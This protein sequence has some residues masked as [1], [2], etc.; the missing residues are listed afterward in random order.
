MSERR[1]DLGW[2]R[3]FEAV[4]RLGSLTAAAQ[5]LG[6]SQPAVSYVIR[7]VEAQLGTTLVVRG[8]RGSALSPAGAALHRTV[9]ASIAE[10]DASVRSVRRMHRGPVL[11]LFTDYGFASFWM[12][13]RVPAF[14]RVRPDVE[15]R[16]I[17]SASTDLRSDEVE[18]VAVLF[19]AR[20]DFPDDAVLLFEERVVPVCSPAFAARH[21]LR[22]RPALIGQ[23]PL[24]HL[25][26]TPRPRWFTWA[27]WLGANGLAREAS[28]SDLSLNTYGLVVQA[29]LADQGL[30]LGWS[31]LIDDALAGGALVAVGAPLMRSG[32][33]YWLRRGADPSDAAADFVD[34]LQGAVAGRGS[35]Q[36]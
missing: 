24:L 4:G 23:L 30:A 28:S 5:E 34:W 1:L 18:D 13:P 22:E 32:H 21:G 36:G 19:G 12:M 29:A 7:S 9:A 11:R 15:V 10:I 26:S 3:V 2:M 33:G 17:A 20:S 35:G 16:I 14:R 31:G 6:L 25:D 8:S 27:D